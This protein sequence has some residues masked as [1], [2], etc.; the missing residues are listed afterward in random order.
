[1]TAA[2][3]GPDL[4]RATVGQIAVN[5]HDV[6]RA[7]Q[8]YRD[9]LGMRHLFTFAPKMTFF[10]CGG[11]RL[12]LAVPEKPEFD[13]PSSVIYYK[14]DDITGTYES[15]KAKGV[16]FEDA[17]HLIAKMPDHDLWMAFFRDPDRNVLA[18]MSEVRPPAPR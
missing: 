10:D 16:E 14:V 6:M 3:A 8:F 7:E 4:K 11:V 13:H 12:Y 9:T 15:L 18:L 17:P 1:M 2:T 5:V